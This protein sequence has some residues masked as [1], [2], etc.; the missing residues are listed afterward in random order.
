MR[1]RIIFNPAKEWAAKVAKEAE[2][3]L[4]SRK[5]ELVSAREDVCVLIGGDGTIFYNKGNVHG[6]VFAIGSER[7]KVCQANSGNWK[8]AIEKIMKM[9]KLEVEERTALSVKIDGKDV[10]WALN[11]AVVHSRKHNFIE[12]EVV[13]GK[14]TFRFGGDGVIISTPTGASGYA[15]SAGGFTI[16]KSNFLVEVV[17]IC[18]YL[19]SFK[20]R[21]APVASE[22]TVR[23]RGAAD[24]ILD[25]QQV[26]ELAEGEVVSAIGDRV[27]NFVDV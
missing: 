10:G 22:I 17:A 6:A 5:Q 13:I 9:K 19:R 3:L 14:E 21:L 24:L 27:I 20:P 23:T 12:N 25:G 7:S 4:K 11:D 8:P 15:Y 16:E 18:P 2:Q 26:I 1:F